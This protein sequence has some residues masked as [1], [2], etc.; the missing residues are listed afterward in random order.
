ML[1]KAKFA[2]CS[3]IHTK[4]TNSM[5]SKHRIV[6]CWTLWYV[7]LPTG[8][9]RLK[10]VRKYM[11]NVTLLVLSHRAAVDKM[12]LLQISMH[13]I[14]R[15]ATRHRS[16]S[17]QP[18]S[19][20]PC[21]YRKQCLLLYIRIRINPRRLDNFISRIS[22]KNWIKQSSRNSRST[23]DGHS[24]VIQK[25][26]RYKICVYFFPPHLLFKTL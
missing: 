1:Y 24:L 13:I 7:M 16:Y 17:V 2:V 19:S 5:W 15:D 12:K 23:G 14:V 22:L 8:F 11:H 18:H 4:H 9:K 25:H 3:E 20:Y 26:R 6:E 21:P 10:N